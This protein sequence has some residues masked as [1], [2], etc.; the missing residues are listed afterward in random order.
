M[1]EEVRRAFKTL[2]RAGICAVLRPPRET[3]LQLKWL[4]RYNYHPAQKDREQ[5]KKWL[6]EA[7][8]ELMTNEQP[9]EQNDCPCHRGPV[10]SSASAVPSIGVIPLGL[11]GGYVG[12]PIVGIPSI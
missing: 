9:E 6:E 11:S 7:D 4:S 2:E 5:L 1:D 12:M 3:M 8:P 10:G